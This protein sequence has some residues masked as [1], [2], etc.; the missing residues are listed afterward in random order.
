MTDI[1]INADSGCLVTHVTSYLWIFIPAQFHQLCYIGLTVFRDLWT[2]MKKTT[3]LIFQTHN[4]CLAP[5]T[6]C[7]E[8]QLLVPH[9]SRY[10][11]A[12]DNFTRSSSVLSNKSLD[13]TSTGYT[14]M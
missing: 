6:D 5:A 3:K 14:Y 12:C 2:L 13:T 8:M 10:V 4:L 9:V 1:T 7:R 11:T